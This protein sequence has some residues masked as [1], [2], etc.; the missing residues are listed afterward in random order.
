MEPQTTILGFHKIESK[1][2]GRL[3]ASLCD[4]YNC[5]HAPISKKYPPSDNSLLVETGARRIASL[6]TRIKLNASSIWINANAKS[7]HHRSMQM[8]DI[9][10]LGLGFIFFALTVGYAIACDHL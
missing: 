2:D 1:R 4:S 8:L 9:V 3:T 5:A 10:M 6:L 7:A